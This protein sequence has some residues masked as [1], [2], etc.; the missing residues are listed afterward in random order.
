MP[1]SYKQSIS[2]MTRLISGGLLKDENQLTFEVN[3]KLRGLI[4]KTREKAVSKQKGFGF[5]KGGD[6]HIKAKIESFEN[7]LKL[8]GQTTTTT[9][10]FMNPVSAVKQG[11][12]TIEAVRD[13]RVENQVIQ[14]FNQYKDYFP[15]DEMLNLFSSLVVL[16][17]AHRGYVESNEQPRTQIGKLLDKLADRKEEDIDKMANIEVEKIW[18][19]FDEFV[20]ND[21]KYALFFAGKWAEKVRDL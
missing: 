9:A 2:Q 17:V 16:V 15:T 6:K 20:C 12:N 21:E 14:R 3:F 13:I 19:L 10:S 5:Q 8:A 1:I 4:S 11:V 18:D 7:A